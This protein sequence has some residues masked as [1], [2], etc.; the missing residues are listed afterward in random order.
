MSALKK[1]FKPF[2]MVRLLFLEIEGG[3]NI[4]FGGFWVILLNFVVW[5]VW[6]GL[7]IKMN[8]IQLMIDSGG[9][10]SGEAYVQFVT[11]DHT[12]KALGRDKQT[13]GH[14]CRQII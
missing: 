4:F 5:V 13:I 1:T 3:L 9:R 11:R 7:E 12:E 8:G 2:L 6:A 14:R 10:S